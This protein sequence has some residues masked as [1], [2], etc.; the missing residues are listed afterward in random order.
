[1]IRTGNQTK[2]LQRIMNIYR[3]RALGDA[4]VAAQIYLA[5]VPR[6]RPGADLP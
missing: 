6:D 4:K 3:H 1:M 2:G 5:L